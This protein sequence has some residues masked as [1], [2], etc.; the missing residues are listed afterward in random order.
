M[1]Q[2]CRTQGV[3]HVG[4]TVP[5]IQQTRDFFVEVLG[6]SQV[7]E[8]PA[9]PAVFV[10]DGHTMLTLW[11]A[12]DPGNAQSFDRSNCVGLHHLALSVDSQD[13]LQALHSELLD[14]EDCGVEFAP[15]PL[16]SGGMQHMM[17]RIPGGLRI[18]F[19]AAGS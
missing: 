6:F 18:E 14:R 11:Q 15:E 5:N 9:Y 2:E 8:K 13:T 16:G 12:A 19:V 3:H 17:T 7:G 4:L 10:S 1:S